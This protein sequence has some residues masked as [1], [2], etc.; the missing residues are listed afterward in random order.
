MIAI[1]AVAKA[2]LICLA[3]LAASVYTENLQLLVVGST[4]GHKT[5][6]SERVYECA[7]TTCD[8]ISTGQMQDQHANVHGNCWRTLIAHDE[9]D[10]DA[11]QVYTACIASE[12]CTTAAHAS[13]WRGMRASSVGHPTGKNIHSIWQMNKVALTRR[14]QKQLSVHVH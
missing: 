8:T 2:A 12:G 10:S 4:I 5:A 9:G 3:V 13:A 14:K 7:Q 6:E 11:C 1:L